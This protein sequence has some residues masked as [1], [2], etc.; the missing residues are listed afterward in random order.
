MS[1]NHCISEESKTFSNQV[2]RHCKLFHYH[3]KRKL[4]LEQKKNHQIE[5]GNNIMIYG[6]ALR[7]NRWFS[8]LSSLHD[9]GEKKCVKKKGKME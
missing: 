6:T 2:E 9:I 8:P 5:K 3:Q 1:L 4:L 7:C